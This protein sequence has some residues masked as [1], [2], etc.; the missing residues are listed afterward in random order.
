MYNRK[1]FEGGQVQAAYNKDLKKW[2]LMSGA[3]A[4]ITDSTPGA[5]MGKYDD[6]H[7][8]DKW[9]NFKGLRG[10][11]FYDI[12][13]PS[14]VVKLSEFSTG[15]TGSGTHRNYYDG[16]K[17]AYL[18]TAPDDTFIHQPSDLPLLV[19]GNMVVDCSDPSNAK[20]VSFFRGCRARARARKPSMT[21]GSGRSWF[22]P[23]LRAIRRPLRVCT[24]PYMSPKSW[25]TEAP[26]ATEH[27]GATASS[28]STFPIQPIKRK[29]ADSSRRRSTPGMAIAFHTIYCGVMDRGFVI[30]NGE[31]TNSDCNQIFLPNWVVDIRDEQQ[32][33]SVAQFPRPVPPPNAPYDDFCFKRGRFGTHN[34]PHLK[35]PGKPR[36]DFIAHSYFIGGLRCYDIGNLY[37]PEEVAYFIPPQGGDLSDW[38]QLEPH[39]GQR[40]YRMG[41]QHYLRGRR[42]RHLRAELSEPRKTNPRPD[43]REGMVTAEAQR[44]GRLN[45]SCAARKFY[46]RCA[47][48]QRRQINFSC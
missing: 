18:D 2:I 41:P 31:T 10:V 29:S 22:L 27:S 33:L 45:L 46:P 28:F 12:S 25:K 16:G 35:A 17:Y 13:D 26:V 36:Q 37:K 34:P 1:G 3:Q 14:K 42:H 32:P 19:N 43:A 39:R 7:L 5:A 44:R 30:T 8:A 11:R 9:R 23:R 21:N 48:A 20:E 15:A 47:A 40:L 24:A 6:P 38:G 4:P